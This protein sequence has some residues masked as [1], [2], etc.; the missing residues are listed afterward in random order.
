MRNWLFR[1]FKYHNTTFAN[2]TMIGIAISVRS[3]KIKNSF[4]RL[5]GIS[6]LIMIAPTSVRSMICLRYTIAMINVV[7]TDSMPVIR[8]AGMNI[9]VK[10]IK[11]AG[12]TAKA[13]STPNSCRYRPIG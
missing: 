11:V 2:R 12:A 4:Q 8:S 3:I 1:Q 6:L 13:S 7:F 9:S 10:P 5:S